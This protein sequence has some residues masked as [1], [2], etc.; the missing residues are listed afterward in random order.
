MPS[1]R[2]PYP[3]VFP[4][5]VVEL[6]WSGW[7]P[8]ELAREFERSVR[9]IRNWVANAERDAGVRSDGLRIQ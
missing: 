3:A 5:P 1:R 4:Q 6:L 7:T 9:A 8:G 2:P